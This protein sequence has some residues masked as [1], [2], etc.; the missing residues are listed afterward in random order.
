MSV[1]D[2]YAAP[3]RRLVLALVLAAGCGNAINNVDAAIGQAANCMAPSAC[4]AVD[5]RGRA[6]CSCRRAEVSQPVSGASGCVLAAVIPLGADGGI[7]E[8]P[9]GAACLE[10]AQA[11][12]GRAPAICPGAGA[13]CLPAGSSCAAAAFGDP[14]DLVGA[15]GGAADAG[16][17][18]EPRCAFVDDVCCPGMP[19]PIDLGGLDANLDQSVAD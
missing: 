10:P 4:Y 16:P 3:M 19:P 15:S 13:Y 8:C 6:T 9:M 17:S 1:V 5:G 18:T 11:C 2:Q 14:P 7:F 12:V